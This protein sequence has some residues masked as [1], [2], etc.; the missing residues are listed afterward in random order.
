MLTRFGVTWP[1]LSGDQLDTDPACHPLH[2]G[3]LES[4][5]VIKMARAREAH[6]TDM[7]LKLERDA[8]KIA[9]AGEAHTTDKFHKLEQDTIKIN[10][11]TI[12]LWLALKFF[13][14]FQV[15]LQFLCLFSFFICADLV[16]LY[17]INVCT[18]ASNFLLDFR[19]CRTIV[20]G[21]R[22]SGPVRP[23]FVSCRTIV[24]GRRWSGPIRPVS[25]RLIVELVKPVCVCQHC[26][27][28]YICRFVYN[29]A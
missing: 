1:P 26:L 21:R 16:Y 10:N 25:L 8:V 29:K 18:F 28:V 7:F 19:F 4:T 11:P 24:L 5:I 27:F 14:I 15:L 9:R 23:C 22:W 3:L 20:L 13:V 2:I 6:S 12:L 17:I